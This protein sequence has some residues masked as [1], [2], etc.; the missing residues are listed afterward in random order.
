MPSLTLKPGREKSLTRRHPWIFSGAIAEIKGSPSLGETVAVRDNGGRFLAW[1]AYS[2]HSQ[3]SARVWTHDESE[4]VDAEF[5]RQRLAQA[6]SLRQ[7]IVSSNAFR[8]AH[9]ES[10]GLPGVTVD[11]YAEVAVMQLTSA[12]AEAWRD[13]IADCLVEFTPMKS[14]FERSE[15]AARELEG[16]A[17]RVGT[18]RGPEPLDRAAITENGLQ[19]FVDVARG[20]KTGFYLDQRHNRAAVAALARGR[21]VLDC[22]CYTGGFAI[23]ALARGARSVTAI[24]SSQEALALAR[25]NLA[26]NGLAEDRMQWLHGDVFQSLRKLRDESRQYD[27]IILDPPRFAPTAGLVAKAARAYKD[28][29]LLAFKLLTPGGLLATFSC[30][31]AISLELFQ[32]IVAGAALDAGVSAQIVR[33]FHSAP[34]HPVALN[35][36]EGEYLKGLLCR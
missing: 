9:A 7:E 19:F 34:D 30:S 13:V 23:N 33:Y 11:R 5:F 29:N 6:L 1:A 35:F 21:A 4:R 2:P 8:L 26:G 18:V 24:D 16:L 17:P 12:G 15:G 14:V 3:I 31:G 22:F 10:D 20:H 27:L 28:I 25:E 32:K 36:P